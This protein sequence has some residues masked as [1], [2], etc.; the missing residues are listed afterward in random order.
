[1]AMS[2]MKTRPGELLLHNNLEPPATV[3]TTV[4]LAIDIRSTNPL[5]RIVF[6]SLYVPGAITMQYLLA[7]EASEI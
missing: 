4:S 2:V 3:I 7:A 6:N 1:M 5:R